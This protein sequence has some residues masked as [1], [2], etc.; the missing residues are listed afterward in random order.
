MNAWIGGYVTFGF[1]FN[2]YLPPPP[3][4]MHIQQTIT[5]TAPLAV[6]C[7]VTIT[8]F[9]FVSCTSNLV[10]RPLFATQCVIDGQ[11]QQGFCMYIIIEADT[12]LICK[13]ICSCLQDHM[14]SIFM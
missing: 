1:T 11:I 8:D 7:D 10:S 2:Q 4:H 6:S 9:A 14:T 3:L 13:V 5:F 12:I